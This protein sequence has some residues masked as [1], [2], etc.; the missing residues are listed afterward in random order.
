M[1]LVRSRLA[2]LP[3][4]VKRCVHVISCPFFPL[5]VSSPGVT[6]CYFMIVENKS[7]GSEEEGA[8]LG[9]E[10]EDENS[11]LSDNEVRALLSC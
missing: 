11:E 7:M 10:S 6:Y 4:H 3:P 1:S 5:H 2:S 8:Q 9:M